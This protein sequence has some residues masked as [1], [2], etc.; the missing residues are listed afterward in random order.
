DPGDEV[1]VVEPCFVAY[2]PLVRLA[3]GIP[4]SVLTTQEHNFKLTPDLIEEKI[5]PKTKAIMISFPNNPTGSIMTKQ[6]LAA[7][8]DVVEKHDLLVISDEI[9]AELSYDH[10]HTSFAAMPKM[11]NRTILI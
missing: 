2:E 9:Y 3:G 7:I 6:E 8:A 10:K 4:V 1:L 5:T 11:W